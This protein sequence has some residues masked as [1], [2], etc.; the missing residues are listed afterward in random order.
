[1]PSLDTSPEAAEVLRRRTRAMTPSQRFEEGVR[2]CRTAR[3]IMRSGIRARHPEYT[4][5]QV[6]EALARLLWGDAL[7]RAAKPGKALLD[8]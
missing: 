5:E 1:M 7:Y 8:P 2:M 6:E 4:A 3:A